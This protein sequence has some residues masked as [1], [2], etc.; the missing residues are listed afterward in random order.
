MP[1]IKDIPESVGRSFILED[2]LSRTQL[3]DAIVAQRAAD[4]IVAEINLVLITRTIAGDR[5]E[6]ILDAK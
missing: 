2:W 5:N 3:H 1:I 6:V 4:R